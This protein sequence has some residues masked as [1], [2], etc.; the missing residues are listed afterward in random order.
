[1][2]NQKPN[3]CICT[4]DSVGTDKCLAPKDKCICTCLDL[5]GPKKCRA[6]KDKCACTCVEDIT[7]CRCN[8]QKDHTCVCG[9]TGPGYGS[10]VCRQHN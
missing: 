8:V 5:S 2:S 3:N 10:H 1:M 6:N 9:W 7:L 4:C